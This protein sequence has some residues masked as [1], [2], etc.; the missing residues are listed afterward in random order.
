[1]APDVDEASVASPFTEPASPARLHA[2]ARAL[3]ANGFITRVV[4]T[5]EDAKREVLDLI[6]LGSEVYSGASATLGTLGLEAEFD[7]GR[8]DYVRPKYLKLDRQTQMAELRKLVSVPAFMLTSV[9][10]VTESGSLV[11][12][13]ASGSQIGAVA[14]GAST[15]ILVVG[16]QKIVG[17]LD[18]AFRRIEDYCLPIEDRRALRIYSAHSGINKLLILNKE[19]HHG[20]THVV[21]VR[22]PLGV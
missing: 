5:A 14:F 8:Y 12:A 1:V 13:S 21:L 19:I 7:S 3:E 15:V 9:Q 16:A 22:E 20:H 6:P 2:V 17:N 10:A 4:D 11:L 18:E